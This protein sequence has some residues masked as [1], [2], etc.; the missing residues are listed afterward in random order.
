MDVMAV[1]TIPNIPAD[2]G[3]VAVTMLLMKHNEQLLAFIG[4]VGLKAHIVWSGLIRVSWELAMARAET[5]EGGQELLAD[6]YRVVLRIGPGNVD[7]YQK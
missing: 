6:Q 5:R 7:R 2:M 1:S 4:Q 3:Q